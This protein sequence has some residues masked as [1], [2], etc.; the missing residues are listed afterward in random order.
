MLRN[1][2]TNLSK[3]G[4]LWAK[5]YYAF[6]KEIVDQLGQEKGGK[7]LVDCIKKYAKLRG[8]AIAEYIQKN[9]LPYDAKSFIDNFDSCFSDLQKEFLELFPDKSLVPCEGTT[10][11]PYLE[12][13]K[14]LE[15]GKKLA[16]IYCEEFHKA[17]W[18]AYHPKLRVRQDKIMARDDEICTF[19]TYMEGDEDNIL[20]IF[21]QKVSIQ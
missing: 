9:Q 7:L 14:E 16:L 3:M 8:T 18:E 13:W 20:L 4:L 2:L 1:N 12:I 17:M 21:D 6:A 11:C 5:L 15:D 19:E 10:F